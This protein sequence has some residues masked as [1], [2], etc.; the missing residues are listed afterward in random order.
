MAIVGP[1]LGAARFLPRHGLPVAGAERADAWR[2]FRRE[3]ERPVNPV[4]A[5]LRQM[6][7][8]RPSL[9]FSTRHVRLTDVDTF[10]SVDGPF[11]KTIHA[12]QP[13]YRIDCP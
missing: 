13:V 5:D 4:I 3:G 6:S 10:A 1:G 12:D 11:E 8:D 2:S 7:L 9:M